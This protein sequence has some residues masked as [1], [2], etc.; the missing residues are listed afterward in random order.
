MDNDHNQLS[1]IYR[2]IIGWE[3]WCISL[4]LN[5]AQKRNINLIWIKVWKVCSPLKKSLTI[6]HSMDDNWQPGVF[7]T[8]VEQRSGG[9]CPSP[10]PLTRGLWMNPCPGA[11]WAARSHVSS[12]HSSVGPLK[13]V[14][15][16]GALRTTKTTNTGLS[17]LRS[18]THWCM[19]ARTCT[20]LFF[21]TMASNNN[22]DNYAI[23]SNIIHDKL[24][25]LFVC[26]CRSWDSYEGENAGEGITFQ[27]WHTPLNIRTEIKAGPLPTTAH[28]QQSLQSAPIVWP[29]P[30]TDNG[31]P[32]KKMPP[33]GTAAAS[34][35]A[36]KHT[37][38]IQLHAERRPQTN[39]EWR[40]VFLS[41]PILIHVMHC[42]VTSHS[43]Q[44]SAAAYS[45]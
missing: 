27:T 43:T 36:D 5:A 3:S 1:K 13:W 8:G 42:T 38:H 33:L 41:P 2:N 19:H 31:L 40:E 37:R 21:D 34:H 6:N 39:R 35:M 26:W 10:V 18:D 44:F 7:Q 4:D 9:A 29:W 24:F 17:R 25:S 23:V 30:N 16:P 32:P 20:R 11:C 28:P 14:H 22:K 12:P 15:P 45:S